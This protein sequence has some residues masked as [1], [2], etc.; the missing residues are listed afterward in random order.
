M[1]VENLKAGDKIKLAYPTQGYDR[2][3]MQASE[4]KDAI[5]TIKWVRVEKWHTYI[6]VE[7]NDLVWNSVQFRLE[8]Q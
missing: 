6:W 8:L 5:F 4:Y 2:D 1:I 3:M 7:E